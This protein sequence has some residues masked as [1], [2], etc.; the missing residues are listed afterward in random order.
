M[1]LDIKYIISFA[2]GLCTITAYTQ[3]NGNP[4]SGAGET[5][6]NPKEIKIDTAE[7]IY[8]QASDYVNNQEE[9]LEPV[10]FDFSYKP[11]VTTQNIKTMVAM[12]RLKVEKLDESKSGFVRI[13]I[14]IF[15]NHRAEF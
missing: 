12:Y 1:K 2:V 3:K 9:V 13:C 8:S 7:R 11:Q 5:V 6:I 10:T 14:F 15:G 4:L